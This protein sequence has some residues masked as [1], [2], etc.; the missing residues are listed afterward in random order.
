M[1]ELPC[2]RA[3]EHD[4]LR[5]AI[6]H[7]AGVGRLAKVT[8]V[9]LALALVLLLPADILELQI[10]IAQLGGELRDVR[11]VVL[12]VRLGRADDD[13]EVQPDV[14]APE[15]RPARGV[16]RGQA[17]RVV[18]RF[19]RGEGEAAVRRPARL[20]DVVARLE[21][22]W[23]RAQS[24]WH[25]RAGMGGTHIDFDEDAEVWVL[26]VGLRLL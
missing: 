24:T 9:R 14:R 16:R 8:E 21:L 2:T 13:V 10:Q 4:D 23:V 22:L 6:P 3:Y 26:L 15:P 7:R 5:D 19:V 12:R 11:A 20:D 18:A 25:E 1:S 17:D